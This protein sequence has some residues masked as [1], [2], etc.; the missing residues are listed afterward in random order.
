MESRKHLQGFDHAE[1][2]GTWRENIRKRIYL[3]HKFGIPDET[4]QAIAVR[5][6]DFLSKKASPATKE[7][8]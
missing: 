6:G 7:E 5:V 1:D 2:W 8:R 3:A 4:I